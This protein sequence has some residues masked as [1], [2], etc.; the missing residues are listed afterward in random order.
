MMLDIE[1]FNNTNTSGP[2]L[3]CSLFDNSKSIDVFLREEIFYSVTNVYTVKKI[4]EKEAFQ[5]YANPKSIKRPPIP[6]HK[7]FSFLQ[8][9]DVNL[10]TNSYI[11]QQ[12]GFKYNISIQNKVQ[13]TKEPFKIKFAPKNL[14]NTKKL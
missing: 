2:L 11:Y 6:P 7:L 8:L 1:T 14:K 9:E 5:L 10:D 13:V 3:I 4:S 12:D